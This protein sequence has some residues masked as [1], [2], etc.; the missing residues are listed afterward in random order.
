[1]N[2]QTSMTSA[3]SSPDD[4]WLALFGAWVMA[5]VATLAA[6]FIGEIMGQTPCLLCWYQRV[7]M[8]PLPLILGIG[9]LRNDAGVWRY[10]LPLSTIGT[11]V[12][13]YHVLEYVGIIP[14]GIT[15]CT[16]TGPSCSG[17]GMTVFGWVPIPVLAFT[18][19][20]GISAALVL[21]QRKTRS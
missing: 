17:P 3:N 11:L 15:P 16:A 1:M 6:L 14:A 9:L 13:A 20:L 10:A 2:D 19:F 5:L 21:A 8:F 7:F 12:A 18:S 4:V